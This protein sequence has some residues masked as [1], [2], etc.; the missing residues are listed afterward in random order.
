[1]LIALVIYILDLTNSQCLAWPARV[2]SEHVAC[3]YVQ[4]LQAL[5]SDGQTRESS[6]DVP[7]RLRA[8]KHG[9]EEK[10]FG[11]NPTGV[12]MPPCVTSRDAPAPGTA[13]LQAAGSGHWGRDQS[14]ASH[15]SPAK[16]LKP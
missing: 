15:H 5:K 14:P 4:P 3:A 13:A 9:R 16:L 1:M 10:Q 8:G 11:D 2:H 7:E 6:Q 12:A